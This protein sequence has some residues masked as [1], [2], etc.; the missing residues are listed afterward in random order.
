MIRRVFTVVTAAFAALVLMSSAA[1][2][3]FCTNE[4][5]SATGNANAVNGNG[6]VSA[7]QLAG[8]V[9]ATTHCD[10]EAQAWIAALVAAGEDPD[11]VLTHSKTTL[12]SGVFGE[13]PQSFD[14]RGI[15]H[16]IDPQDPADVA[17]LA[18]IDCA[19]ATH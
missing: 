7:T 8:F 18:M 16:M 5:R 6:W 13:E 9:S 1:F 11:L 14:D 15:D 2:A 3:H 10:A 4:S 12:A 19:F 17:F